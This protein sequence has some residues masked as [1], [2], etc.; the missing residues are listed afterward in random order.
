LPR[1]LA[2]DRRL[3]E[4]MEGKLQLLGEKIGQV[5]QTRSANRAYRG[6]HK[7]NRGAFIDTKK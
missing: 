6:R 4:E 2:D 3:R 5:K 7:P 1:L